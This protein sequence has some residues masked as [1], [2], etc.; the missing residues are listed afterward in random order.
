MNP[1]ANI[2]SR[3]YLF[4]IELDS[5]PKTPELKTPFIFENIIYEF[6]EYMLEK[7][8]KSDAEDRFL[9]IGESITNKVQEDFGELIGDDTDKKRFIESLTKFSALLLNTK[10]DIINEIKTI[11]RTA[12]KT[13]LKLWQDQTNT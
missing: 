2:I 1:M 13:T 8:I 6:E 5:E 7:Q 12:V 4:H 11:L 9:S 3:E 10:V